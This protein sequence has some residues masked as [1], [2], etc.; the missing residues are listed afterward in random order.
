MSLFSKIKNVVVNWMGAAT[1]NSTESWTIC[2]AK[3]LEA[4]FEPTLVN[5]IITQ[6]KQ[7]SHNMQPYEAI[8][9]VISDIYSKRSSNLL[10]N[11]NASIPIF[12]R[13][14]VNI[15]FLIGMNG[16]GK[17]SLA[18]KLCHFYQ[19]KQKK[20]CFA[21][22]DTFRAAAVQQLDQWANILGTTIIKGADNADPSSVAY[23]SLAYVIQNKNEILII[24]T[25]GRNHLRNDLLDELGKIKRVIA[26]QDGT[27]NII[28]ILVV[29][30]FNGQQAIQQATVFHKH[31]HIDGIVFTKMDDQGKRGG[32][33]LS[34]A[35][36]YDIPLLGY[37]H[38]EK[39]EHFSLF[40]LEEYLINILQK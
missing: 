35:C 9:S 7:Y 38:G 26:K 24:D 2:A 17:T 1:I 33:I 4:D 18:A 29:D 16:A 20:V 40:N 39:I 25:A 14:P 12:Q 5:M 22:C 6:A 8:A 27:A 36:K 31:I 11:I 21:A 3:M 30:S 10:D 19:Q 37:T 34:L 32:A 28:T 15:L 13:S 23:D